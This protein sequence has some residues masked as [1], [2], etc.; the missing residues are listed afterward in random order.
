MPYQCMLLLWISY[1][2]LATLQ[3][4]LS[5][6][7]VW[8]VGDR[9]HEGTCIPGVEIAL[10]DPAWTEAQGIAKIARTALKLV[11][12]G[13]ANWDEGTDAYRISRALKAIFGIRTSKRLRSISKE[14][15]TRLNDIIG[16]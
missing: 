15:Q 6:P 4:D 16:E 2:I 8:R 14:D 3:A 13:K 12:V 1:L 5:G 10:L 11:N 7:F 9:S